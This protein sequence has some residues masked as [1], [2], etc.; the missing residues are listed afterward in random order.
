MFFICSL[1]EGLETLQFCLYLY[2][3]GFYN[4]SQEYNSVL[5]CHL[6]LYD[7]FKRCFCKLTMLYP[8]YLFITIIACTPALLA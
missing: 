6:L 1:V 2:R 5:F 3:K 4:S 7:A 8:T